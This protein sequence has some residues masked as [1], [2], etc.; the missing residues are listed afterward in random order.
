MGFWGAAGY[1]SRMSKNKLAEP[2][3]EIPAAIEEVKPEDFDSP[4]H[5]CQFCLKQRA[6]RVLKGPYWLDPTGAGLGERITCLECSVGVIAQ[7]NNLKC[8][9]EIEEC[10]DGVP[11]ERPSHLISREI[12]MTVPA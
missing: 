4:G 1:A 12:V 9:I 10:P 3:A 5:E 6:T 2:V 7:C 8:G 11:L